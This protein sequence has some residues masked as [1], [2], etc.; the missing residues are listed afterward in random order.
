M[1]ASGVSHA[2][3]PILFFPSRFICCRAGIVTFSIVFVFLAG[4]RARRLNEIWHKE[5]PVKQPA[6]LF[7]VALVSFLASFTAAS[8]DDWP[9]RPVR[10]VNTF[11]VGGAADVLARTVAEHLSTALGQQFYV[12]TRAGAAGSIGVQT[13]TAAAPDGYNTGITNGSLLGLL[14]ITNPKLGFDPRRDLTHIAYIAGTPVVLSV[15]PSRG[16]RTLEHFIAYA[17]NSPKP[18]TYS[19]SGVGSNGHLLAET[20]AFKTGINVEH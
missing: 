7:C 17:K 10:I 19:S 9:N 2:T 8:A 18:M 5:T 13:V 12:E 6:R 11:A 20:F 4:L 14:P 1:R 3:T 15:N 16:F